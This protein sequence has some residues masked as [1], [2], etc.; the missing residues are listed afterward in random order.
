MTIPLFALIDYALWPVV[1]RIMGRGKW[2]VVAVRFDGIDAIF[3]RIAE[4]ESH[5]AAS[6]RLRELQTRAGP[7]STDASRSSWLGRASLAAKR[8]WRELVD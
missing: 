2:Y 8:T 7:G 1:R 5:A 6:A 4:A 3:V